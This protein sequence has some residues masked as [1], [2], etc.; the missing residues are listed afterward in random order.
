MAYVENG[1][2]LIVQYQTPEYDGDFGPFP[3]T[4]TRNPEEVSEEDS[5]VTILEPAHL[6]FA[7]P[8]RITPADFAG[9]V[10]ERGSKFWKTWDSRYT[11]LLECHDA[12]Q[13]PQRGG[14]L[15]A[16]YGK[17]AFVY[18]AYAWY[19]QLPHGI[20]GAYRI[21]ANLI[22]LRRTLAHPSG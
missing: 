13:E 6:L 1:G 14:M 9:W 22:S 17:G 5:A 3:Y 19:R 11:P 4:M 2:V 12:G 20:P 15:F 21:V 10:E 18:T 8:N 16:R 7:S